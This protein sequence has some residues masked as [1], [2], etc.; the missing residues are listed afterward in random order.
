[1]TLNNLNVKLDLIKTTE[2]ALANN[3]TPVNGRIYFTTDSKNLYAD[4]DGTRHCFNSI[5]YKSS[6]AELL[7]LPKV[8]E[9]LYWE[10]TNNNAYRYVGNTLTQ[11]IKGDIV[12]ALS[13]QKADSIASITSPDSLH[14]YA[15]PSNDTLSSNTF[16]LY[17]YLDGQFVKATATK[18]EIENIADTKVTNALTDLETELAAIRDAVHA[19]T[20]DES[21]YYDNIEA[22]YTNVY[23]KNQTYNKTEIDTA[24]NTVKNNATTA[25]E[26]TVPCVSG[27]KTSTSA[28]VQLENKYSIYRYDMSL[29]TAITINK[30]ALALSDGDVISFELFI[31]G[32]NSANKPVF[33]PVPV[34]VDGVEPTYYNNTIIGFRTFDA[35][36]TW[37]AYYQGGWN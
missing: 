33:N 29:G 34:W 36:E 20:I 19:G 1:M 31:T 22:F 13:L 27:A 5:W 6:L 10:T 35:G 17:V 23:P 30:S 24:I 15:V 7:K 18:S 32:I 14:V 26:R 9:V 28:S 3:S 12:S 11:V 21:E 16:D 25:N 8:N 2:S 4:L 37:L